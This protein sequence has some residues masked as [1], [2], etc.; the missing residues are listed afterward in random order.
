MRTAGRAERFA[1]LHDTGVFVV[2][3]ASDPGSAR[4]LAGL[5]FPAL[6]T[7]SAGLAFA[8]RQP[9]RAHPAAPRHH[10]PAR[11]DKLEEAKLAAH[12]RLPVQEPP[13]T[14]NHEAI[15]V[16][17]L[18]LAMVGIGRAQRDGPRSMLIDVIAIAERTGSKP[19]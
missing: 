19:A 15:A 3:N 9:F 6:A 18:N 16:M 10:Q 7:T 4:L 5:G 11:P 17:L 8:L 13:V 14:A 2:A 1:R 12:P